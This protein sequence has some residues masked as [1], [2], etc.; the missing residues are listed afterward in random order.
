MR[1]WGYVSIAVGAEDSTVRLVRTGQIT[2]G[3]TMKFQ[4]IP[5]SALEGFCIGQTENVE[6]GTG[7]TVIGCK[8]GMFAGLAHDGYARK[9]K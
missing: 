2:G 5:I 3:N 4:E 9:K 8:D 6:A 7:L 1:L